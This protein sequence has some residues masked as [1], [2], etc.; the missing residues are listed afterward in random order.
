MINELFL[1][2]RDEGLFKQIVKNSFV[3]EGRYH[4]AP[5]FGHELNTGNLE[6]YFK[7][8]ASGMA[9]VGQ[10][11]PCMVCMAPKSR[12]LYENGTI[13]EQFFFNTFF[14][15]LTGRTSL[16]QFK[17]PDYDTNVSAHYLWYDWQDMKG[18]ADSF[19]EALCKIIRTRI[20]SDGIRLSSTVHL[21]RSSINI[22]RLSKF[23]NDKVSGI[24]LSFSMNIFG[25]TCEILDYANGSIENMPIPSSIIHPSHKQ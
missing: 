16:N 17:T 20:T 10:K 23:N 21:E 13:N 25:G 5:H 4:I 22:S 12:Q 15:C 19:I 2:D 14:L 8:P 24:S 9:D 6:Q 18:V 11:Y 3:L 7:D 1:Y